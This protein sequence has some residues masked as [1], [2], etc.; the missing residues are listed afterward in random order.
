MSVSILTEVKIFALK[1]QFSIKIHF[2]DF[3]FYEHC[4]R[5]QLTF[6]LYLTIYRKHSYTLR[7]LMQLVK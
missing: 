1:P 2:P 4:G 6:V 3:K 5:N 7:L